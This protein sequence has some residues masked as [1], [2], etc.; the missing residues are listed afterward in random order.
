MG[1]VTVNGLVGLTLGLLLT[2]GLPNDQPQIRP[3]PLFPG[4]GPLKGPDVADDFLDHVTRGPDESST[5]S[6]SPPT[7]S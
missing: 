7:H 6:P 2:L 4:A 3:A 1:L 5:P